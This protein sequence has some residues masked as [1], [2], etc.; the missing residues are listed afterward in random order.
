MKEIGGYFELELP[1]PKS[2][3][4]HSDCVMVN[5]GRHA[6][7]YIL[8]LL[9]DRVKRIYLPYYTCSAVIQPIERLKLDFCFYSINSDF[10]IKDEI[11]L[12]PGE[13]IIVNNYFGV[14][15]AYISEIASRYGNRMIIDNAQAWYAPEIPEVSAFYSPRKYFGMP[16]GGVVAY[17]TQN[18]IV[19]E[20]DYSFERMSHLIKRIDI[21]AGKGYSDF[22]IN[23]ETLANESLKH[24]SNLSYRILS[25]VDFE[26]VRSRRRINFGILDKALSDTNLISLPTDDSFE[27]PMVYPYMAQDPSLRKRLIENNIYVATYWPNVFD[28]CSQSTIEYKLA[29]CLIPLP[30]DQRY[31][32]EDMNKIIEMILK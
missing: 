16:D 29:E 9:G 20:R 18:K 30:I 22:R 13:Y 8:R 11:D 6:L 15:D 14:K 24:M 5:S 31:N 17:K 1:A 4:M 25:S 23:S 3:F 26:C 28:W 7:E 21:N 2:V 12:Q 19:L 32:E 10:E 27:C